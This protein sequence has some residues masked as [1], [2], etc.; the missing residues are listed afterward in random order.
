MKVKQ[1]REEITRLREDRD[2][3]EQ[4]AIDYEAAFHK[5]HQQFIV[6]IEEVA[7]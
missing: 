2:L 1:L 6:A 3:Y 5:R 7:R 4:A